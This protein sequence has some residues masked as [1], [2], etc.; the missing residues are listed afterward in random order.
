[1]ENPA[2]IPKEQA[3][4][5]PLGNRAVMVGATI[6]NLLLQMIKDSEC[7]PFCFLN[8]TLQ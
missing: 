3:G 5:P 4:H 6:N 1:M 8:Q 2:M 7:C